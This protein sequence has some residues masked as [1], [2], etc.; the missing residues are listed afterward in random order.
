M[1]DFAV[2][3]GKA[4]EEAFTLICCDPSRI[5]VCPKDK[6]KVVAASVISELDPFIVCALRLA[7]FDRE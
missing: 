3:R 4:P 2:L 1:V 6:D 7:L 5:K